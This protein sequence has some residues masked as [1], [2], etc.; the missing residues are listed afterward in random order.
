MN[1]SEKNLHAKTFLNVTLPAKQY[2]NKSGR[3]Y[4][5]LYYAKYQVYLIFCLIMTNHSLIFGIFHIYLIRWKT[6]T[7]PYPDLQLL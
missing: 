7:A 1:I 4:I 5:E 6:C 2:L 3:I